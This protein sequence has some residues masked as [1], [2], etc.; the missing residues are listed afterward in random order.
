MIASQQ[1]TQAESSA[2]GTIEAQ[3]VNVPLPSGVTRQVKK[4]SGSNKVDRIAYCAKS[5]D[6]KCQE[7][8]GVGRKYT[9]SQ[10]RDAAITARQDMDAGTWVSKRKSWGGCSYWTL[11]NKG[12]QAP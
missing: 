7:S 2:A 11:G 3:N 4:A 5:A 12:L 6:N 8:F 1:S 10:A 9:E